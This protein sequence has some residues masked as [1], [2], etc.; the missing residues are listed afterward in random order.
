MSYVI[1]NSMLHP[2]VT[3]HH[4][5]SNSATGKL[6]DTPTVIKVLKATQPADEGPAKIQPSLPRSKEGPQYQR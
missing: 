6:D 3:R 5:E 2:V 4:A 1:I